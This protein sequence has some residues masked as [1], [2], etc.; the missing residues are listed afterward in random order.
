MEETCA[1]ALQRQL[2][3]LV[4]HCR[5][6]RQVQWLECIDST[7]T[8]CRRLAEAGGPEGLAVLAGEQSAGRGRA[9][10]SF[11]SPKGKGLYLSV[12][13]R[14]ELPLEDVGD[15][16]AWVAVAVCDGIQRA[17]GV[18][19]G[20]KW[21]NDLILR[22]KKLCGILTELEVDRE[23][24][25]PKYIIAGIGVNVSHRAEDFQ[26]EVRDIATSLEMEL[27][28]PVSHARLAGEILRA[29]DEMYAAFPAGKA[30]YLRRYREDCVTPGHEVQLITPVSRQQARALEIDEQ[31]R[32]VARLPDGSVKALSTGEVSVRGMYGYV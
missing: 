4:Q 21:T 24:R 16:T 28:R 25:R 23:S 22:G 18:R 17:C 13:L 12:L 19:P 30:D 14:P 8:Q 6:G 11:Q 20:I 10:R 31:F 5:I 7:N 26:G 32:L 15:L 9:G 2:E 1:A 29:L 27:G 3:Q